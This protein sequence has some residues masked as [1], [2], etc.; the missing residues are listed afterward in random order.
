M[1]CQYTK[2]CIFGMK[3]KEEKCTTLVL[4]DRFGCT[5]CYNVINNFRGGYYKE[6]KGKKVTCEFIVHSSGAPLSCTESKQMEKMM[7]EE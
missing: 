1:F 6:K 5:P 7:S 2:S 4:H 3:M